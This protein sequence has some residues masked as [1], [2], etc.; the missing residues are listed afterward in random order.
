MNSWK[1]SWRATF[2]QLLLLDHSPEPESLPVETTDEVAL[3]L[4]DR[5]SFCPNHGFLYQVIS[6]STTDI[7]LFIYKSTRGMLQNF[8]EQLLSL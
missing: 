2:Q 5:C 7:V 6:E 8:S 1:L 4:R 3:V